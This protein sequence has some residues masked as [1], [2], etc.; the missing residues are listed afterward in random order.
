M[1]A[2][3]EPHDPPALQAGFL[4]LERFRLEHRLGPGD[5]GEQWRARDVK[6]DRPVLVEVLPP[7]P[8]LAPQELKALQETT[9]RITGLRHPGMARVVQF[10]FLGVQ[11]VVAREL[12]PGL[13]LADQSDRHGP[14]DAGVARAWLTPVAEALDA[15]HGCGVVHGHVRAEAVRFRSDGASVLTGLE[16]SP[17]HPDP[18]GAPRSPEQRL[19]RPATPASD[20]YALAALAARLVGGED[21]ALATRLAEAMAD[22]P[23]RRPATGADV[24]ACLAAPAATGGGGGWA[25]GVLGVALGLA[26]LL[27]VPLMALRPGPTPAPATPE[28]GP[29][30]PQERPPRLEIGAGAPALLHPQDAV[31]R[32]TA[33]FQGRET[34]AR[35]AFVVNWE[36]RAGLVLTAHQVFGVGGG[37]PRPLEPREVLRL[38]G[39]RLEIRQTSF[40]PGRALVIPG[41]QAVSSFTDPAR[42]LAAFLVD[43]PRAGLHLRKE[44]LVRDE[45][46][47]VLTWTGE[48]YRARAEAQVSGART[49]RFE[50]RVP[51]GS[52]M[53][54]PVLDRQKRVVGIHLATFPRPGGVAGICTDSDHIRRTLRKV[55]VPVF[56]AVAAQPEP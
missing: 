51:P 1:T 34:R 24:L 54:A 52:A 42:D 21:P 31:G 16:L 39:P 49:Y 13:S 45:S 56:A 2:P 44:R 4:L 20:R 10:G 50:G 55:L 37:L 15:A 14:V 47:V 46:L 3:K 48:L 18:P 12:V 26:I 32:F 38:V 25:A 29:T 6:E 33:R 7:G 23:K 5:L 11:P 22:E 17:F 35:T 19:G 53:G 36:G 27:G 28:P 30:L 9:G 40:Q 8:P 43:E 41:A